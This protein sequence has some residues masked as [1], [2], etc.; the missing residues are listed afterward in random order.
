MDPITE[1]ERTQVTLLLQRAAEGDSGA[2]DRLLPVVY[3]E[4]RALARSRMARNPRAQ[5]LQPTALVHEAY[6]RLITKDAEDYSC[7]RHFFAAASDA[8]R[9]ILVDAARRRLSQKR[10]GEWAR[11]DEVDAWAFATPPEDVVAIDEALDL[12]ESEDAELASLVKLRHYGGLDRREA[13]EA[14]GISE[15]TATRRWTFA[16]AWMRRT[17]AT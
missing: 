8:M 11:V 12:L 15:R 2:A 9:N 3:D 10:G 4:L 16:L 6:L 7:R 17:L 13:A 14:L 5:T 1:D